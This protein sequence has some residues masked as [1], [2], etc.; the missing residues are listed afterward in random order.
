MGDGQ[1]GKQVLGEFEQIVLLS[2]VRLGEHAYG[3]AV[4]EEIERLSVTPVTI[5]A[6]YVTLSRLEKKN[7]VGVSKGTPPGSGREQK[8]FSVLPGGNEALRRSREQLAR[9]W[10]GVEVSAGSDAGQ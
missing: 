4:F 5:T 2:V 1:V 7:F 3:R 9:F 10:D 6:V 8:L